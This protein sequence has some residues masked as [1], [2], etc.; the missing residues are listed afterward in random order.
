MAKFAIFSLL[1]GQ[2]CQ[3]AL[4]ACSG[5]S[6]RLSQTECHAWQMFF[7]STSGPTWQRCNTLRSDPCSCNEMDDA[8]HVICANDTSDETIQHV[9]EISMYGNGLKGKLPDALAGFSS[10]RSLSMNEDNING[11]LP[12]FL[13]T[14]TELEYIWAGWL[15]PD[16]FGRNTSTWKMSGGIPQC[17][18]GHPKMKGIWLRNT[19]LGGSAPSMFPSTLIELGL[20]GNNLTGLL[21]EFNY[22]QFT[23]EC[24]LRNNPFSCPLPAGAAEKCGATCKEVVKDI[25]PASSWSCECAS[26]PF[27]ADKALCSTRWRC[28]TNSTM[29]MCDSSFAWGGKHDCQAYCD[30]KIDVVI[31]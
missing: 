9:T 5:Q 18:F 25:T 8:I 26:A 30:K 29:G 21:P 12:A 7:D 1:F 24:N 22:S 31:V 2:S 15:V 10:L 23:V 4:S 20:E 14:M 19:K 3:R 13:C 11:P 17:L 28:C 6:S 27:G 16:D